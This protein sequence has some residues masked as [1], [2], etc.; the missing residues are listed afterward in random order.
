M[1]AVGMWARKVGRR[2]GRTGEL[3]KLTILMFGCV[4]IGNRRDF[5]RERVVSDERGI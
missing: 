2:F 5:F 4:K 3:I 1:K